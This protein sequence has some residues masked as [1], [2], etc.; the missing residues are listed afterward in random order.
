M[1]WPAALL[2]AAAAGQ[3]DPARPRH[4]RGPP[5]RQGSE[6]HQDADD[7]RTTPCSGNGRYLDMRRSARQQARNA[8]DSF[9]NSFNNL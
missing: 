3:H 5:L 1:A 2:A 9:N 8:V 6:S 4:P 7:L